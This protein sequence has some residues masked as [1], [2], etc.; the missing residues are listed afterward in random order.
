MVDTRLR[1]AN[2]ED[3]AA[4]A[5]FTA[6]TFSWGDYVSEG[7]AT[8]LKDPDVAVVVAVDESDTAVALAKVRMLA[9]R[10]GWLAA[11]RVHSD[12]RRQGLASALNDWCVDWVGRRGGLVAR[13]Q[14]ETWNEPAQAQVVSLGYRPVASVING[15][16]AVGSTDLAPVTNGGRRS[17]TPDSL[18]QSPAAEAESAYVAWATSDLARAAHGLF[19]SETWAWRRV[20]A[21]D[22]RTEP[23]WYSSSGWVIVREE[24]DN[25]TVGWLVCNPDDAGR[26]IRSTLDLAL[27]HSAASLDVALPDV[28]WLRDVLIT[29]GFEIHPSRIYEKTVP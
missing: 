13:L 19:A 12:H 11:A 10:E 15:F 9:P 14:I 6:D 3:A 23:T 17:A 29:H 21:H 26:L 24:D 25:L 20:G 27:D 8:W 28:D 4:I 1:P 18:Q 2:E 7:F 16:R 5:T 22:V